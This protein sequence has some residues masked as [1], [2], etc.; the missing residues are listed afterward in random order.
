VV[1]PTQNM[2]S[3]V[4]VAKMMLKRYLRLNKGSAGYD[5]FFSVSVFL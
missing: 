4:K 5:T 3:I 1:Q 2:I